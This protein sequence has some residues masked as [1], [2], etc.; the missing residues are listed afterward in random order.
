MGVA[1]VAVV[2]LPEPLQDRV[3]GHFRIV[4]D[5]FL[6]TPAG[7]GLEA[8]VQEELHRGVGKDDAALVAALADD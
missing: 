3:V 8:G 7:T 1:P 5:Q 6:V 4:T 2:A